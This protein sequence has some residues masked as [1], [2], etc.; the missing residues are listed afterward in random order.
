MNSNQFLELAKSKKI[1][2]KTDYLKAVKLQ[3]SFPYFLIPHILSAKFESN[4]STGA[5]AA[6]VGFAAVNTSDRA[7]LKSILSEVSNDQNEE[8]ETSDLLPN[9]KSSDNPK[10]RTKSLRELDA[11]M[12]GVAPPKKPRRRRAKNDELIET[13]KKKDKKP[14]KDANLIEQRDLIKAFSKKSIK[15]AAIKEIELNQ[16]KENLA[17]SSTVVNNNLISEPLAKLLTQQ[18]KVDQARQI[19][20]KLLLKF[21]EKKAYFADLIEKLKD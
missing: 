13:I 1:L 18:G 17:E 20:E 10:L 3:E 19:Y 15:L 9:S 4:K 7:W 14:I 16:N 5:E 2:S 8:E 6:S 12:K 11:N 21:P